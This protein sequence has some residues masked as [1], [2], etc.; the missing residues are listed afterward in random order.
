VAAVVVASGC[1]SATSVPATSSD[2]ANQMLPGAVGRA[3]VSPAAR[4]LTVKPKAMTFTKHKT[5]DAHMN[6]NTD[7]YSETDNCSG[8]A[9]AKYFAYGIWMITPGNTNGQC[10]ITF[11]DKVNGGTAPMKVTNNSN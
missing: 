10:T 5:R 11:K 4:L 7:T 3:I 6:P 1:Q 9:S 2:A 8:I